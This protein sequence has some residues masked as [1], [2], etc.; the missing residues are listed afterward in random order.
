MGSQAIPVQAYPEYAR[1]VL[2]NADAS[3]N[4]AL[5]EWE[6]RFQQVIMVMNPVTIVVSIS[7]HQPVT[8]SFA[9]RS[10]EI[11]ATVP[12]DGAYR[13][14][15]CTHQEDRQRCPEAESHVRL[16]HRACISQAQCVFTGFNACSVRLPGSAGMTSP[17]RW[18]ALRM[19]EMQ[20]CR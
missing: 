7:E 1:Y 10:E 11:R 5:S 3:F 17:S 12:V 8:A 2:E 20:L 16:C 19:S 9:G 14:R 13:P 6:R 4:A 18:S 15:A